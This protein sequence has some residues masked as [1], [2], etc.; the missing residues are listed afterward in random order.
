MPR[1]RPEYEFGRISKNAK[2]EMCFDITRHGEKIGICVKR[3]RKYVAMPM[4]DVDSNGDISPADKP[5]YEAVQKHGNELVASK[6]K[7]YDM[8]MIMIRGG[9]IPPP[10]EKP[11]PTGG[12]SPTLNI[13]IDSSLVGPP[14]KKKRKK[15]VRKKPVQVPTYQPREI[16]AMTKGVEGRLDLPYP[17]GDKMK[18]KLLLHRIEAAQNAFTRVVDDLER[19]TKRHDQ[20]SISRLRKWRASAQSILSNL[21]QLAFNRGLLNRAK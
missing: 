21:E 1:R 17:E 12:T 5:L 6:G 16:R 14:K 15:T 11:S 13:A 9:E 4:A 3:D 7:S 19:A 18:D 10:T 2:G 20:K 8:L